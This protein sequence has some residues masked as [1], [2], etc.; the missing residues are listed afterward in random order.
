VIE[1]L[2]TIRGT[3]RMPR[4]SAAP[5]ILSEV[6]Q[7]ELNQILKRKKT[8][9]QIALRAKIIVLAAQN[10]SHGEISK[11]LGISTDYFNSMMAKPFNWT[12]KGKPLT[13]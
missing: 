7:T 10:K 1:K 6:E 3:Q 9:Q 2:I 13:S 5:I 8:P 11:V 4:L 12:Y